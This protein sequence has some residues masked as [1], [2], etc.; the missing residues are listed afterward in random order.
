M[1]RRILALAWLN[2]LQLFRNPAELMGLVGLPVLLTLLFGSAFGGAGEEPMQ[3]LM[4]D[5]DGSPRAAQVQMLLDEE[6]SLETSAVA[7]SEAEQLISE[8]EAAVAVIVAEGFGDDVQKGTA[9]IEV[10]RDPASESAF[11]VLSV[12]QGVATRMSGDAAA[13]HI[14]VLAAQPESLDFDNAYEDADSEWEPVPPISAEGETVVA[15]DVRGDEVLATGATLSSIGFTVWFILFMTF[16][17]AGGILEEREQGTLRRLLVAPA[18]RG[19]LVG[20]K[21]LGVF[22][23]ASVQ[24]FILVAIGALLFAVPWGN[25]PTAVFMVLGS[26]IL[27][28]TGLAILVSALVRT[29]D[30]MAGLSPIFATGLAMLGGCLWPIEVV[31]PFM[32][33]IAKLTPT[34]WAVMGLTDIVARNQGIEAAIVPTIVLL[35]FSAVTLGLGVR[36]LKFE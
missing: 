8:G 20:G 13:A 11:A 14:M 36:F 4:V 16:G 25:N 28:A 29:R 1:M 27:A 18:S 24:A 22:S 32:Q 2:L 34:G 15:S 9:V 3:V 21:V 12:A 6:P 19:T 5:E 23:T 7:R 26:Y 31:S 33:T 30:Q 10:L 35:G 17:S